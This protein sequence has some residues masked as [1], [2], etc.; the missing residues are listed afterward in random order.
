MSGQIRFYEVDYP[1]L[2]F[3]YI[4]LMACCDIKLC[5]ETKGQNFIGNPTSFS[6]LL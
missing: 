5:S 2:S 6:E 1:H 4:I 3:E